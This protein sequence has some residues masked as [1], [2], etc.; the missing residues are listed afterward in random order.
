VVLERNL[1]EVAIGIIRESSKEK[2][3]TPQEGKM[4]PMTRNIFPLN[5]TSFPMGFDPSQKI[6]STITLPITTT[7]SP[8]IA[9]SG[10]KNLPRLIPN[11]STSGKFSLPA[12]RLYC[13][14]FP[15]K[16]MELRPKK[17]SVPREMYLLLLA[18][19]FKSEVLSLDL[20]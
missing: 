4:V 18:I 5:N 14:S 8:R 12:R 2:G 16:T 19:N 6:S 9:S 13:F 20:A 7:R 15:L 3:P 11:G 10:V 1:S 17:T